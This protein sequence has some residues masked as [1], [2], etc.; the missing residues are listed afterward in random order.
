MKTVK[1]EFLSTILKD[2][3]KYAGIIL[4]QNKRDH[5][6]HLILLPTQTK[7]ADWKA[8]IKFANEISGE[9]PTRREQSLLFANLKNEFE[10][11]WYWSSE[12]QPY[13]ADYIW[14]QNFQYGNQQDYHKDGLYLAR[15][16][17]KVR[18]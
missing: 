13:D 12:N 4:G 6:Y 3:E 17:R 11:R 2:G 15:A 10:Y 9:L 8:A 14:G 18:I 1:N 5:D 7:D 16:V